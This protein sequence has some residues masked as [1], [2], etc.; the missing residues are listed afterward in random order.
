MSTFINELLEKDTLQQHLS[1]I[2]IPEGHRRYSLMVSIIRKRLTPLGVTFSPDPERT[3]VVG[4][5]YVWVKLPAPLDANQ[6]CEKALEMQNLE[7]GNGNLFSVPEGESQC[8]NLHRCLR[9]CFMWEDDEQL[10]E[11]ID[12]LAAVIRALL[13]SELSRLGASF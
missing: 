6:V 5:Y 3:T 13:K 8:V 10:V 2:V 12:R 1:T 9:L 11:G 4:G 7:L